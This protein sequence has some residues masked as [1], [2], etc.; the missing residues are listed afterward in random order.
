MC[1]DCCRGSGH[2]GPPLTPMPC[3]PYPS[4]QAGRNHL[5]PQR[6]EGAAR[7][8]RRLTCP[9]YGCPRGVSCLCTC[10]C[11]INYTQ[12]TYPISPKC[13]GCSKQ[14]IFVR[15]TSRNSERTSSAPAWI[16][17]TACCFRST[18]TTVRPIFWCWSTLPTTRTTNP[19]S[20]AV[21]RPST[22]AKSLPWIIRTR[23]PLHRWRI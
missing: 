15:R 17:A 20:Y 11:T 18:A 23:P 21:A 19:V 12:R 8:D 5:V 3:R 16:V 14:V 9:L 7:R 4:A 6:P 1:R 10:C 13:S 2:H 22:R